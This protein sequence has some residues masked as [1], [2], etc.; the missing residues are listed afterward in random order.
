MVQ[1][2]KEA[3]NSQLSAPQQSLLLIKPKPIEVVDTTSE[4]RL[5][6]EIV[7][8]PKSVK[9]PKLISPV[10][11]K[12]SQQLNKQELRSIFQAVGIIIG[13]VH[14]TNGKSF[15]NI[16]GKE[17]SLYYTLSHRKAYDAL[18]KEI[19]ATGNCNQ[20]LIV[21]PRILHFPR[22][23]QP[24]LIGF[25]LVGFDSGRQTNGIEKQLQNF[26]FRLCGLWQF[27]PVCQTPC[28]S[29]FKNFSKQRLEY[30]KQAE[31]IKKLKFMKALH[32]PL[33]WR[34][35]PASPFRFNPK[36]PKEALG[37]PLFMEVLAKFIPERDVFSFD[38]LLA[39]PQENAPKFL[40][41]GKALKQAAI[42][43]AKKDKQAPQLK[44][45][46]DLSSK[47]TKSTHS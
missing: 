42:S 44:Q 11:Q 8:K 37:Q 12:H 36:V 40:K 35:A 9:Q 34:D 3:K 41:A 47:E 2:S 14:F 1:P 31:P 30:I 46:V 21:Y 19:E 39:L 26:Q 5:I 20:R 22:K 13:S 25:Q 17:Y 43:Y 7:K 45:K 10:T 16:R 15:V 28:I 38:S 29:V 24:Y 4:S 33:I 32:V 23:E 6:P 18:I 27:I